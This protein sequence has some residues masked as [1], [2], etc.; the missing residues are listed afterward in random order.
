MKSN[1]LL[2]KASVVFMVLVLI[3]NIVMKDLYGVAVLLLALLVTN[4]FTKNRMVVMWV[5]IV[6]SWVYHWIYSKNKEGMKNTTEKKKPEVKHKTPKQEELKHVVPKEEPKHAEPKEQK[7]AT[8]DGKHD[9]FMPNMLGAGD[10][11]ESY[12]N[13]EK[14]HQNLMSMVKMLKPMMAQTENLMNKMPPGMLE[15][16]MDKLKS[17]KK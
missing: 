9:F 3:G 10:V 1:S 4:S 15:K 12:Q 17:Y 2:L 13:M 6:C 16:A 5:A 11:T 7:V 14:Q 8:K